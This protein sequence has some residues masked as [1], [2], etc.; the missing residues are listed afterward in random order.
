MFEIIL[1]LI[2]GFIPLIVTYHRKKV[3]NID[4]S[5][6][7]LIPILAIYSLISY[8]F[9]YILI[10]WFDVNLTLIENSRIFGTN[11]FLYYFLTAI[12]IAPFLAFIDKFNLFILFSPPPGIEEFF[13]KNKDNSVM[14]TLENGKV[15]VGMLLGADIWSRGDI[16]TLG[17][18]PF[19]S[20]I[21][22][23][24]GK[25]LKINTNYIK[26]SEDKKSVEYDIDEEY[27]SYENEEGVHEGGMVELKILIKRVISVRNFDLIRFSKYYGDRTVEV[28]EN[29]SE[30]IKIL[31]NIQSESPKRE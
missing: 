13:E 31:E 26:L 28:E 30:L 2:P 21:R 3:K 20:G 5:Q 25:K 11:I 7:I 27:D 24:E 19:F 23:S 15:Y 8:A 18:M 6:W 9:G 16:S 1:F 22:S 10:D 14:V 29:C 12:I 4:Y 17:L